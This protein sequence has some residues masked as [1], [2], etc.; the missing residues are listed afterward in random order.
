MEEFKKTDISPFEFIKR[1]I[2]PLPFM[3]IDVREELEFQ[4]FNFGGH[5]IPL[6]ILLKM[7]GD[8]DEW[9]NKE[10]IVICQHGLRSETARRFLHR[11]GFNNV[12]NLF[13]GIMALRKL[14][15]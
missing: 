1:N 6:G 12:R 4:T 10:V 13:G 3:I 8:L 9:K 14:N 15:Y 7:P 11:N 5:N 2:E